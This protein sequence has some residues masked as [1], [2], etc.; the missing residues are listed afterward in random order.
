MAAAA[1][2]YLIFAASPITEHPNQGNYAYL[3]VCV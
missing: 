2:E 3:Y 1:A